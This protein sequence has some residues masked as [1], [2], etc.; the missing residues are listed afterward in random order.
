MCGELG[1]KVGLLAG[2]EDLL[3]GEGQCPPLWLGLEHMP[4][5]RG[6]AKL[7]AF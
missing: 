4:K 7:T 6:P 1:F 5:A 3:T 2:L